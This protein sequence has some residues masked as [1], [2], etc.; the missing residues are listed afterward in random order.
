MKGEQPEGLIVANDT[1]PI[2]MGGENRSNT[3]NE[4]EN[5]NCF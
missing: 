5:R 1:E 2:R 4:R 3:E